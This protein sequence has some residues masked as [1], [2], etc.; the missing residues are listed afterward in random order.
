MGTF[1][2]K[3]TSKYLDSNLELTMIILSQVRT[4]KPWLKDSEL[5]EGQIQ[6][7]KNLDKLFDD[8]VHNYNGEWNRWKIF[9]LVTNLS[10]L[11]H[12]LTNVFSI[13][14]HAQV[15]VVTKA[16]LDAVSV[17]E[18]CRCGLCIY[19]PMFQWFFQNLSIMLFIRLLGAIFKLVA[20]YIYFES[21]FLTANT[22]CL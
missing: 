10:L 4:L 2:K 3:S 6:N 18:D 17:K 7:W 21:E 20:L 22:W 1:D 13:T 15:V 8:Y 16:K 12:K 9:H 11:C 19:E 5:F 14:L